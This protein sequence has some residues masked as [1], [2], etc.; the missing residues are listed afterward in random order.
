MM[1]VCASHR[2]TLVVAGALALLLILATPGAADPGD[3]DPTFDGDGKVTTHIMFTDEAHGVA[4]QADG[5]IV[6]AGVTVCDGCASPVTPHDFALARYHRDGSIDTTF[7]GDGKVITDFDLGE[8]QAFAVAIQADGKI[9]AAGSANGPSAYDFAVARYNADGSLDPTFDVDGKVTTDFAGGNDQGRGVAIQADGK[10]V[11]AGVA[12]SAA[13]LPCDGPASDNFGLARYNPDGSLDPTFGFVGRQVTDFDVAGPDEARGVAVQSDGKIVA[14]GVAICDPCVLPVTPLPHDFALA[15]YT[16]D[17]SL[18]P[19]FD[20]DGKVK[21]DF[22]GPD[23]AN[24][25]ALQGDGKIVAA[26]SATHSSGALLFALARYKGD[27][28][29]DTTFDGDGRVTTM[30]ASDDE[31]RGV[32]IQ[33]DEKIVAAGL[34]CN[35]CIGGPDFGLARYNTNGALDTVFGGG[36]GT[37]TTDFGAGTLDYANAV[38]IQGDGKIVGAGFSDG[39]FALARY[40]VCRVSSRRSSIPCR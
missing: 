15:R 38:A 13:C 19:T 22:G 26:G 27:G 2:T 35:L 29:L 25:V 1:S 31:A 3:L 18:D 4:I 21:T 32:A 12:F 10:I 6:A 20:G 7:D 34:A 23:E 11:V 24:A 28:A 8:D 33:R 5:K 14:A 9:I 37:V 36:D 30:V 39:D 17:G 16:T 40:K